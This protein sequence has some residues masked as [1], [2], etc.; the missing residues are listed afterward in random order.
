MKRV[1]AYVYVFRS[2]AVSRVVDYKNTVTVSPT[3]KTRDGWRGF[4]KNPVTLF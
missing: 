2:F 1:A 4:S 3:G